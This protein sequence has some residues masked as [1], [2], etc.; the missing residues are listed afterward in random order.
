MS[1][2]SRKGI[3]LNLD[4]SLDII[5]QK[6]RVKLG[7]ASKAI[8]YELFRLMAVPDIALKR[9]SDLNDLLFEL[10]RAEGPSSTG[11]TADDVRLHAAPVRRNSDASR[12]AQLMPKL[13][14]VPV[15]FP[16]QY[17]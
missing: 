1:H 6:T 12:A 5:F 11:T 10:S 4:Y 7:A 17:V 9:G 14:D 3:I 2:A 15:V 8:P 16:L 13:A